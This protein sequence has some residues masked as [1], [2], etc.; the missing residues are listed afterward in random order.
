MHVINKNMRDI[1]KP[2]I[3]HSKMESILLNGEVNSKIKKVA[4]DTRRTRKKR[5]V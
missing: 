2:L 4:I 1:I 5:K 3:N